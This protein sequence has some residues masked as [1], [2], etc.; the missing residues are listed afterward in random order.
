[1]YQHEE[2]DGA[3]PWSDDRNQNHPNGKRAQCISSRYTP[4]VEGLRTERT[5]TQV[6]LF[7]TFEGRRACSS[8][9][10]V[11]NRH[12]TNNCHLEIDKQVGGTKASESKERDFSK[13]DPC[14]ESERT[15]PYRHPEKR[16]YLPQ[17]DSLINRVEE[18]CAK[19]AP[20][21]SSSALS[22]SSCTRGSQVK[23]MRSPGLA[24]SAPPV[25]QSAKP[26]KITPVY[27]SPPPVP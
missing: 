5:P 17:S 22:C 26:S 21:P 25:P 16:R 24:S 10:K 1:M 23:K 27:L 2:V 18:Q 13:L 20:A 14:V 3:L 8:T 15:P 4:L 19:R 11:Q 6:L 9:S 12:A 7:T